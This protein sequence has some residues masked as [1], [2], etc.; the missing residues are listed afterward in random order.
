MN[1]YV[2]LNSGVKMPTIGYGV[3]L[4][5]PSIC[6]KAVKEALEYKKPE[7]EEAKPAE[8]PVE[9]PAAAV[10]APVAEEPK[11]EEQKAE[12]KKEEV[13]AEEPKAEEP[14]KPMV[15]I[16]EQKKTTTIA[17]SE[18]TFDDFKEFLDDDF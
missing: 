6:A 10:T 5:D 14:K 7:S 2:T 11:S 16:W 1:E 9:A 3:Y 8:A 17:S 13:K 15:P 18:E 4:V 12:E